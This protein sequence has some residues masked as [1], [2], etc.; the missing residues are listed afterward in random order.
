LVQNPWYC[1]LAPGKKSTYLLPYISTQ[2]SGQS[3]LYHFFSKHALRAHP[4]VQR[5]VPVVQPVEDPPFG[6]R[7]DGVRLAAR[8]VLQRPERVYCNEASTRI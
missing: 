6:Q 5:L 7:D 4:V 3:P 1:Q 2:N 8:V